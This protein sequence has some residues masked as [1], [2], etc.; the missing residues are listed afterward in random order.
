MTARALEQLPEYVM[1][2]LP[3]P[4]MRRLD[5]LLANDAVLAGEARDI[6]HALTHGLV[7]TLP[8]ITPSPAVRSR[9]LATIASADRWE[10]FLEPLGRI[11]QL[12]LDK[13]RAVLA[14]MADPDRWERGLPGIAI[15]HFDAGP[16]LATADA[17]LIKFEPGVLFP[18]HRHIVGRE[19]TFVLEGTMIDGD[20]HYGPGSIVEPGPQTVHVCGATADRP[21]LLMVM[22]Y[23]IEPV[24]DTA[25]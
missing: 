24:F 6:E 9:L 3:A 11:L 16:A 7:A 15:I 4:E 13:V 21:L 18:K 10:P 5:S 17:G 8:P 1:H 25:P 23:G 19:I 2:L 20:R 22:H 12:S 14:G